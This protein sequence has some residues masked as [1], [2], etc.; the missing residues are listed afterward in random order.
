LTNFIGLL[1][2]AVLPVSVTITFGSLTGRPR[3][4]RLLPGVMVAIFVL[5]LMVCDFA[6]GSRKATLCYP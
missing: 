3:A 1:A 5:G 4:S 6:N 2:I